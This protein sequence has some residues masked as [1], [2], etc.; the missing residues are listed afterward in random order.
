M[1]QWNLKDY[2]LS[3]NSAFLYAK[4]RLVEAIPRNRWITPPQ[5]TVMNTVMCPVRGTWNKSFTETQRKR[6]QRD[7]LI[8]DHY[9]R[10]C[11]L[12]AELG[13]NLYLESGEQDER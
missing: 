13:G 5:H 3:T 8:W 10:R 1:E 9:A 6:A 12:Q 2:E 4:K 7:K 11:L